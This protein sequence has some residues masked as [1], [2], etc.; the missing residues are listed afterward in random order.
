MRKGR[1]AGLKDTVQP[2]EPPRQEAVPGTRPK[3]R[4]GK[5]AVMGYFSHELSRSLHILAIENDTTIQA[6]L[7]EAIDDLMRK[8]GRH[9]FGER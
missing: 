7:G 1:F 8:K 2:A 4:E 9:P 5:K 3:V 6:L